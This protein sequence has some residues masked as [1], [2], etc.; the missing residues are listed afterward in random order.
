MFDANYTL[1]SRQHRVPAYSLSELSRHLQE[2]W[3]SYPTG[4]PCEKMESEPNELMSMLL[5]GK[6]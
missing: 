6:F 5:A 2:R 1:W 3:V 4:F